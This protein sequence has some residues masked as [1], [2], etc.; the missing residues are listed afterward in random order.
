MCIATC[1]TV[2]LG[3][4]HEQ[5]PGQ[6]EQPLLAFI[7]ANVR[8]RRERRGLTQENLSERAGFD[9]RFFR[10]IEQGRKDISV[11]TLARLA[12]VLGCDPGALL[13]PTRP[14]VRLPGRPKRRTKTTSRP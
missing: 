6:P 8:R 12:N 13:R 9:I 3:S 11:S 2:W 10:F 5:M 4:T 7:A 1:L 14:A